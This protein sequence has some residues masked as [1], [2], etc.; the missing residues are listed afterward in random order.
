LNVNLA[1]YFQ[2]KLSGANMSIKLGVNVD[3][4][5]TLRQARYR[6]P[7]HGA[8]IPEP[9]PLSAA[10]ACLEAGADSITI[11][12][13][14]DRRH[15]QDQDVHLVRKAIKAPLNFEMAVTDEMINFALHIKPDE[16]C[17]VPEKREEVT[18]EGG[19]DVIKGF[20]AISSAVQKLQSAGIMV[21][22]FIDPSE[23]QITKAIETKAKC[24]ELHTG[25]YA[26]ASTDS[27]RENSLDMLQQSAIQA[28]RAGL[29][30]NAGHGLHYSN[31]KTFLATPHL[32][33]LNIGHSIVSRSITVGIK[34]AVRE[35]LELMKDYHG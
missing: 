5:A 6:E 4:V 22:I 19:L 3:H 29:Q 11:H 34:Q 23:K 33:T 27:E 21:S 15:I 12:L 30:V 13:R 20:S 10:L 2:S 24:I 26:N 9:D 7:G 14:E 16:V 28:H 1:K 17:L 35:M 18:T 31:L 8:L 32:H 25:K